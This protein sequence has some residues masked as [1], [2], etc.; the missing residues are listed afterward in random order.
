MEMLQLHVGE[1]EGFTGFEIALDSGACRHV[2]DPA[3]ALGHQVQESKG[4]KAAR[5]ERV[6]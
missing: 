6:F 5:L 3:E 2:V 4:S 1:A